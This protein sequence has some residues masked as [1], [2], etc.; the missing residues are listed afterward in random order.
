MLYCDEM[1]SSRI[2]SCLMMMSVMSSML[3]ILPRLFYDS[4]IYFRTHIPQ[5]MHR[6]VLIYDL[7]T[8]LLIIIE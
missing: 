1:R 4:V 7:L 6:A 5:L 2:T 3:Y 8:S